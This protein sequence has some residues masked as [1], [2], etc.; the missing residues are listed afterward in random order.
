MPVNDGT[1]LGW[2]HVNHAM[3]IR[4][5]QTPRG[6]GR[7][8]IVYPRAKFTYVVEFNIN[9]RALTAGRAETNLETFLKNGRL[10]ATLRSIDHPKVTFAT[11]T[12]R[13]YNKRVI[14]PT[15]TD[16]PSA[17][18]SFHDDNSSTAV[19][20]WKEIRAFYHYEG[21]IGK[22]ALAG[23]SP[24]RSLVEEYR[25]ASDLT[26]GNVRSVGNRPSLGMRLKEDDARHFF[27]SINIYD[28]GADPSSVN[29]YSFI[30]PFVTN[31]DHEALDYE[32]S[33]PMGLSMTFDYESYYQLVG[34]N[35]AQFHQIIEQYLGFRP[36]ATS[37]TVPGHASMIPGNSGGGATGGGLLG[38]LNDV[39]SA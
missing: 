36:L 24:T 37:P 18:M 7:S 15:R 1:F 19:A 29:V 13:S 31:Y 3:E 4:G 39:V 32:D 28:L 17:T 34:V 11:E 21:R 23:G 25:I 6:S 16:Y 12:L 35:N 27:D 14:L 2:P 38:F 22:S 33:S 5:T 30:Y 9:P 20:L 10:Y 8:T 26:G